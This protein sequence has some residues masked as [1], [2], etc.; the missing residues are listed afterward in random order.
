MKKILL[1]SD[2]HSWLDP[3]ILKYAADCDEVWHAGD[4]GNISVLEELQKIKPVRGVYGNID[5]H[6]VRSEFEENLLFVVEGVRI[7]M[8]HIGGRPGKYPERVKYMIKL[9]C[10][11]IF[12]CGHSHIMAVIPDPVFKGLIYINPGAAG[13]E[14]FHKMRTIVRM[15]LD[16]GKIPKME[17][18]ELGARAKIEEI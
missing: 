1:I 12:I 5:S 14:G 10:P 9:E 4:V 16:K 11:K 17:V 6:E 2:T 3:K 8:T 18:L 7:L 13:R 15:E